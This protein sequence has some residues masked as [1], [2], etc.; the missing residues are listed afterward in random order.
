M[1]ETTSIR[2][3]VCSNT[4]HQNKKPLVIKQIELKALL[5]QCGNKLK[6]K[7]AKLFTKNGDEINTDNIREIVCLLI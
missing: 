7:A 4:N 6:M 3:T 1:S 2:V 5:K